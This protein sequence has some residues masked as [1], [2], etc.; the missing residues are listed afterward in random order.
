MENIKKEDRQR[1]Y[2]ISLLDDIQEDTATRL[3]VAQT[4]QELEDIILDLLMHK[5][6]VRQSIVSR[7][8]DKAIEEEDDEK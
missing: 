5:E 3:R 7:I 2:I 6:L 1:Q 8:V 4:H